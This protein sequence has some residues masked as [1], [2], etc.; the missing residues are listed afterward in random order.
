MSTVAVERVVEQRPKLDLVPPRPAPVVYEET[1]QWDPHPLIPVFV[2]G[3]VSLILSL[4][5]IGSILAW[6]ALRHSGVMAP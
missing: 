2:A 5:F 6:L 1:E 4:T 3:A